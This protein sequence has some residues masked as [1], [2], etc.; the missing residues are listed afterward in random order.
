MYKE[1]QIDKRHYFDRKY[2]R[3]ER[4]FSFVEQ[5]ELVKTYADINDLILEIGPGNGFVNE[6]SGL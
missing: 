4:M 1:S 3:R 5:I 6:L 2:L